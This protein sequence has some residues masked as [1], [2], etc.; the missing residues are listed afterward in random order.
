MTAVL[1]VL[2][3]IVKA[4]LTMLKCCQKYEH[5]QFKNYSSLEKRFHPI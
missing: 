4:Q 2:Q 3:F 5:G 1:L